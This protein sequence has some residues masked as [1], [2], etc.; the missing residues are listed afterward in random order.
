MCRLSWVYTVWQ[1]AAGDEHYCFPQHWLASA[2][3]TWSVSFCDSPRQ[4][5]GPAR[6]YCC[7]YR[8]STLAPGHAADKLLLGICW[9]KAKSKPNPGRSS[10][11]ERD[12]LACLA[13]FLPSHL[14]HFT[15]KG[16]LT[17]YTA[18]VFLKKSTKR[19]RISDKMVVYQPATAGCCF[20]N[21]PLFFSFWWVLVPPFYTWEP[22]GKAQ[23]GLYYSPFSSVACFP[24]SKWKATNLDRSYICMLHLKRKE[25]KRSAWKLCSRIHFN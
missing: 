25:K 21:Q 6:N 14:I 3:S 2:G 16:N 8:S 22:M 24:E 9:T 10:A 20:L 7:C 1:S 15:I 12:L 19:G 13:F 18:F 4:M 11:H 23:I 17:S 5:S